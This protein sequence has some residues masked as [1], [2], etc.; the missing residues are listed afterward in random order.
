MIINKTKGKL[1]HLPFIQI[2]NK[3]LGK[4]YKL[5][6]IFISDKKIQILNNIY[7]KINSPTDI[8]S[9]SINKNLGEIFI[10]K[11]I[12]K[13]EA[14]KFEMVYENFII[15]LFIHGSIHLLNYRHGKKM[16][17]EEAKFKNFFKIN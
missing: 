2:K 7:R 8:L 16:E 6:L 17:I 5:N 10:C 1:P 4:K 3:I 15:F 12:A 9:F 11:K 14:K 13:S